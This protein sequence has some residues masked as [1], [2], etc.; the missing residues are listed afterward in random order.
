MNLIERV[1]NI[2]ITPQTEWDVI[3][4]ETATAPGLFTSYVLPLSLVAC[5]GGVLQYFLFSAK[6]G[7]SPTFAIATAAIGIIA[8]LV[9]YYITTFIVDMLAPSF[10]SEKNLGKSAQLVAYSNTPS[11]IARLLSFLPIIGSLLAFAAWGYSIY[12]M[13]LGV[14]TIKKTPEDKKVV[15]IL[16]AIVINIA[17]YLILAAILGAIIFATIGIGGMAAS[18]SFF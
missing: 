15:Y 9:G 1:K 3:D 4:G 6:N 16:V 13:Y 2:L 14:G 17:V 10:G 7:I 18:R 8:S 11:A 5:V 12:L